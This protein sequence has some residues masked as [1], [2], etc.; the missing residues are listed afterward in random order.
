LLVNKQ[1]S[2]GQTTKPNNDI[3]ESLKTF[4]QIDLKILIEGILQVHCYL[5]EE[6]DFSLQISIPSQGFAV[7]VSPKL[8][9]LGSLIQETRSKA[10]GILT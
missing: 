1:I 8:A 4:Y 10:D 7:Y 3:C 6:S 2:K 9:A 5:Q